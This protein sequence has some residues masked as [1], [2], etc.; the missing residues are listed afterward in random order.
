[1]ET[2]DEKKKPKPPKRDD[3]DDERENDR[4]KKTINKQKLR[5]NSIIPGRQKQFSRRRRGQRRRERCSKFSSKSSSSSFFLCVCVMCFTN[6]V[7][8]SLFLTKKVVSET[9]KCPTAAP[10]KTKEL[11]FS[12][13]KKTVGRRKYG[14]K[15]Y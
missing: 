9:K 15:E 3:D 11:N 12:L 10:N 1:M 5:V 7:V 14:R 2:D 6:D 4:E 13:E 8:S